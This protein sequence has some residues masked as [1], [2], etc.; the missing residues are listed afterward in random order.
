VENLK[1]AE[2]DQ[3]V[4]NPLSL[5]QDI[6]SFVNF[7]ILVLVALAARLEAAEKALSEERAARLATNQSLA[8]EK[9][10]QQIV[11]RAS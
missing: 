3:E 1:D 6:C 10:A 11:D 9:A 4:T 2:V 8:E 7:L 5:L